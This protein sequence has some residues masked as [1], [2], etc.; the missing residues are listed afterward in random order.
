MEQNES[1]YEL[2][3][4][5]PSAALFITW[6]KEKWVYLGL[7]ANCL[8]S[9]PTTLTRFS[10]PQIKLFFMWFF[11][12]LLI[13]FWQHYIDRKKIHHENNY[14]SFGEFQGKFIKW[15]HL[16]NTT[17]GCWEELWNFL[18]DTWSFPGG[19]AELLWANCHSFR[20]DLLWMALSENRESPE[21]PAFN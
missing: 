14:W 17:R 20:V 3:K 4:W 9:W 6:P 15:E 10:E 5:I 11:F 19:S 21:V 12:S 16:F 1:Y 13:N 8:W 7:K 18:G 2:G